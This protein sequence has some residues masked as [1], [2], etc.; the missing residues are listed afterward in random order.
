MRTLKAIVYRKREK[1]ANKRFATKGYHTSKQ[2]LQAI[3][4]LLNNPFLIAPFRSLQIKRLFSFSVK[5][6][7]LKFVELRPTN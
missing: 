2:T 6:P 5:E 3:H 4:P 7:A 1:N